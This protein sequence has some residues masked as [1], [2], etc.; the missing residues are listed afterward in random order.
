[1]SGRVQLVVIYGHDIL[2]GDEFLN[3]KAIKR[4]YIYLTTAKALELLVISLKAV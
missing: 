3:K 1:M 2:K 4:K